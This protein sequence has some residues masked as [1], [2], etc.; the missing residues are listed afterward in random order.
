M[1]HGSGRKSL[2][3]LLDRLHFTDGDRLVF[4]DIEVE[5]A[6]DRLKSL[7]LVVQ[8]ARKLAIGFVVPG[9]H[10]VLQFRNS[11]RI[12][13]MQFTVAAPVKV[14]A[15]VEREI[16]N[17]LVAERQ[18]VLLKH[19]AFDLIQ[20]NTIQMGSCPGEILLDEILIEPNGLETL[21]PFVAFE[22]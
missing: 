1:R 12:P 11:R 7:I 19:F 6:S 9:A 17:N 14:A 20:A 16:P 13:L 22:R 18:L 5:Q 10:G 21:S 15:G 2:P 4:I 3:N 8:V